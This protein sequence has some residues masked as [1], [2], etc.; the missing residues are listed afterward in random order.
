M[1]TVRWLRWSLWIHTA[2]IL[3]SKALLTISIQIHFSE[4]VCF[5]QTIFEINSNNKTNASE[6]MRAKRSRDSHLVNKFL[7]ARAE[8]IAETAV[9]TAT[10]TEPKPTEDE[11]EERED[12]EVK[13]SRN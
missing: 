13:L 2:V 11:D 10:R 1:M 6:V 9:T 5:P 4:D 8:V 12:L 7:K 3:L